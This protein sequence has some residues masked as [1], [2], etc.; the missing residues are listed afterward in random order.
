M[1]INAVFI[2]YSLLLILTTAFL[3]WFKTKKW[4]EAQSQLEMRRQEQLQEKMQHEM[5]LKFD[6]L[7]QKILEQKS[8]SLKKDS[9]QGLGNILQPFKERLMELGQKVEHTYQQETRERFALKQELI[10]LMEA[11]Q[12]MSQEAA[13]LTK[14]LKGD[15]K[16]QGNWGEL[17]LERLLE[18]SG[19]RENQEFTLQAKSMDLRDDTGRVQ[20]PDVIIHLPEQKKL[21]IDSKVSLVAYERLLNS[22]V[23]AHSVD[24]KKYQELQKKAFVQSIYQH[25]DQLSQKKYHMQDQLFSPEFVFLFLPLEGAFSLALQLDPELFAYAWERSIV[26]AGPTTLLATMKTVGTLWKQEKQNR[27]SLEIALEAGK[28]YDKFVLVMEDF[29]K[30]GEQLKKTDE[31]YHSA[32]SRLSEGRGN[33]LSK[34]EQ[35]REMGIKNSKTLPAPLLKTIDNSEGLE[36]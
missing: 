14:A 19:M 36:R 21:V 2:M 33:V 6:H 25:I 26:L 29:L 20:R 18:L 22:E 30:I 24:E 8:E 5:Q 17:I 23:V 9:L 1:V 10:R 31:S 13:N 4:C 3:T 27:N 32:L 28:L 12:K 7:A 15:M 34:L 16:L 11:G 35:L